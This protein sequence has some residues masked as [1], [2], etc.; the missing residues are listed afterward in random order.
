MPQER[1]MSPRERVVAALEHRQPD[2]APFS[3]GFCATPEMSRV[4]DAFCAARGLDW[5]TLREAAGDKTGVGPDYIGPPVPH[6]NT[7][8]GIW[9][10]RLKEAD[11][12]TGSY[13]EFTDFPLAGIEDPA[14][15]EDY[16]WPSPDDFDYG[17]LRE[18]LEQ[19]NPGR[20]KAV[21][22]SAGNP[23]EIYSWMTG[24]EEALVNV[25]VNP[26]LVRAAL[27]HI[28]G[29]MAERLRRV[30]ES[31]GD[32]VDIVFYADDLGSQNGLLISRESYRE[33]IQ[34]A[35]RLITGTVKRLAPHARCMMHSDGAVFEIIP[36]LL[37]A[38]LEV[39]EA[40]QTDAAGM[41]PE[42]L[43]AVYGDRLAFHG[44]ISVQQLLPHSD[45]EGV[46]RECR[47]LVE[48]L[49]RGGG[50]IAAPS[51]AIQM[52]TPP[53]NVLAML[54]GVLG[55]EDYEAVLDAARAAFHAADHP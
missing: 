38:G 45:E 20:R 11:Y 10:I 34:P 3:W 37:D 2:R 12:G 4:L 16:P 27:G 8:T 46:E 26:E 49:G 36:D 41:Q 19:S 55:R 13:Q 52:G 15:L 35:H 47:R 25:L 42:R 33:L 17:N 22:Y 6:G 5:K 48:I 29:F 23:F 28:A 39:L 1:R 18:R 50:Y 32:L 44:A 43:K 51:H 40:V 30:L 7:F 21:Q 31:C 9:G 53:E 54:R 24:L 14:A